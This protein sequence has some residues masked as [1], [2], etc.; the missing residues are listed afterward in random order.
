MLTPDEVAQLKAI[1][2]KLQDLAHR[3]PKQPEDFPDT[4]WEVA[5]GVR[6]PIDRNA[7]PAG[8]DASFLDG[9]P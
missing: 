7:G 2:I 1:L 3:E 5:W 8:G 6:S 4:E 9:L